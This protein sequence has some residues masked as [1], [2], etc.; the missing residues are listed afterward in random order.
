MSVRP[1]WGRGGGGR[2]PHHHPIICPLVQGPFWGGGTPFPSIILPLVPCPFWKGGTPPPSHNTYTGGWY[3]S[4]LGWEGGANPGQD[5]G[6]SCLR[7]DGYPNPS[8]PGLDNR[9]YHGRYASC[10][11]RRTFLW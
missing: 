10:G 9:L 5:R 3:P 4:S 1:H 2:V 6:N 8:C 7:L 11:F